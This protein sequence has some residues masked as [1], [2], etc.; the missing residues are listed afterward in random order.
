MGLREAVVSA[1][2]RVP[3]GQYRVDPEALRKARQGVPK[4]EYH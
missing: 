4:G 3:R 2:R 1:L